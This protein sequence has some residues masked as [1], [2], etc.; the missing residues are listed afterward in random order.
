MDVDEED[1]KLDWEAQLQAEGEAQA[2]AEAE[3]AS[4]YD[5]FGFEIG[6]LEGCRWLYNFDLINLLHTIQTNILNEKSIC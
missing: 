6:L 2:L 1:A 5:Q 4:Y 3:E